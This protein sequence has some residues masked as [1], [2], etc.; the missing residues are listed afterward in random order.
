VGGYVLPEFGER[1]SRPRRALVEVAQGFETAV[2]LRLQVA[3]GRFPFGD[4]TPHPI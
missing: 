2:P 3:D 4:L 1:S